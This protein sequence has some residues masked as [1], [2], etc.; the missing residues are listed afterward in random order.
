MKRIVVSLV[1]LITILAH[2]DPDR[3]VSYFDDMANPVE[4]KIRPESW[5]GLVNLDGTP[6]VLTVYVKPQ[7]QTAVT[8]PG[9]KIAEL[10]INEMKNGKIVKTET[11]FARMKDY[12]ANSKDEFVKTFHYDH[13][14]TL[15]YDNGY[16]IVHNRSPASFRNFRLLNPSDIEN[17][18]G[19]GPVVIHG[20]VLTGKAVFFL[21]SLGRINLFR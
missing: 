4:I 8:V 9:G 2:A 15:N 20:V 18:S 6:Q 12:S 10:T 11:L 3:T 21:L 17:R 19:A 14:A 1:G 16:V 13:D 7:E 5:V